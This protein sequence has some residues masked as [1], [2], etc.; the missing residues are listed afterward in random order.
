MELLKITNTLQA[1]SFALAF[2]AASF[3]AD[4]WCR[5]GVW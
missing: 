5:L 3:A 4:I 1:A 2:S